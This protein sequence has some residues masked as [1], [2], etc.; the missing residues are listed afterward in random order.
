MTRA[1]GRV[2]LAV[3]LATGLV[4]GLLAVLVP[5]RLGTAAVVLVAI[6]ISAWLTQQV[7][8]GT[9]MGLVEPLSAAS[10]CS[11]AASWQ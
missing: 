7:A 9:W 6:A 5:V 4:A 11:S 8:N 2:D 10:L 1:S 3:A